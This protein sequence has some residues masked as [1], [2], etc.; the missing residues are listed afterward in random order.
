MPGTTPPPPQAAPGPP[1][2][3]VPIGP[4]PTAFAVNQALGS[5]GSVLIVLQIFT[6]TGPAHY[7][8]PGDIAKKLGATLSELG[9]VSASG[10]ISAAG[11][12]L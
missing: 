5:D 3:P 1:A 12:S 6:P 8:L 4:V 10:L 7:F 9:G 11:K 2:G